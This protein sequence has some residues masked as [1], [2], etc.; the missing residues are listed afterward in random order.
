MQ[1]IIEYITYSSKKQVM[2]LVKSF[3]QNLFFEMDMAEEYSAE[4]LYV[5]NN[6]T[7]R[8]SVEVI[9]N[10]GTLNICHLRFIGDSAESL[11]SVIKVIGE[12]WQDHFDALLVVRDDISRHKS[13]NAYDPIHQ[14]ENDLR[15]LILRKIG[16]GDGGWIDHLPIDNRALQRAKRHMN[17]D[18]Q[19]LKDELIGC[20][21][22]QYLDLSDLLKIL[23]NRPDLFGYLITSDDLKSLEQLREIRNKMAHN[24]HISD[25]DSRSITHIYS[26]LKTKIRTELSPFHNPP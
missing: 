17:D 15:H 2:R 5:P 20:H 22:L 7:Y 21:I 25:E 1:F 14:I 24:R 19:A 3:L 9:L 8:V 6:D 12:S 16:S 11:K 13:I 18:I 23:K 4:H 26:T 10:K